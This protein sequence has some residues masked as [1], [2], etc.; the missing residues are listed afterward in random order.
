MLNPILG[1]NADRNIIDYAVFSGGSRSRCLYLDTNKPLA[2]VSVIFHHYRER[3]VFGGNK[4]V[5]DMNPSFGV[6]N[7]I[8]SVTFSW[9]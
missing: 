4:R 5:V 2:S 7:S 1:G 9:P 3:G 8:L 6:L